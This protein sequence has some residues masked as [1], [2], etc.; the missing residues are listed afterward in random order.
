MRFFAVLPF[1]L[2]V[3]PALTLSVSSAELSVLGGSKYKDATLSQVWRQDKVYF[4]ISYPAGSK[5]IAPADLAPV[6]LALSDGTIFLKA[7]IMDIMAD[8]IS[9]Y[10]TDTVK[11]IHFDEMDAESL[12]IF[13]RK[14]NGKE[15]PKSSSEN[16]KKREGE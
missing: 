14:T 12:A 8:S 7:K 1:F 4:K 5:L 2:A 13:E 6:K 16:Q 10:V 3:L 9:I 11:I 15:I